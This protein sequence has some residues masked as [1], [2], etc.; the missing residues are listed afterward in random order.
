MEMDKGTFDQAHL[1]VEAMKKSNQD[2]EM[3]IDKQSSHHFFSI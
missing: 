2:E 3:R 1:G